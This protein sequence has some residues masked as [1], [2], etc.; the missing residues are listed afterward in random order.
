[1]N[2]LSLGLL[3]VALSLSAVSAYYSIVGLAAVFASSFWPVLILATILEVGKLVLVSWLYRNWSHTAW[4]IKIYLTSAVLILMVITSLGI[5]GFL[6]RAHDQD[7]VT[8][9]QIELQIAQIDSQI[10]IKQQQLAEARISW[11]QLNRTINIQLDANR[12]QQA[13][14]TR[15]VQQ[16]EKDRLQT[17]MQTIQEEMVTLT[18]QRTQ[19]QSNLNVQDSKLGP[20]TYVIGLFDPNADPKHSIRWI[21]LVLVLVC[22]PLAVLMLMAANQGYPASP[23]QTQTHSGIRWDAQH[24][25]IWVQDNDQNW[26]TWLPEQ[27]VDQTQNQ[28]KIVEQTVA[29]LMKQRPIWEV[30]SADYQTDS[31]YVPEKSNATSHGVDSEALQKLIISTLEK[32]MNNTLTV[33]YNLDETEITKIVE[34]IMQQTSQQSVPAAATPQEGPHIPQAETHVHQDLTT[35]GSARPIHNYFGEPRV[36]GG[37]K[38]QIQT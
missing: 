15:R 14:A 28:I 18:S 32:W 1:M 2:K 25:R 4:P 16:A 31:Q 13:L 33:T 37:K 6:S 11:D 24:K 20:V 12:A 21:I 7:Q 26:H 23:V 29:E 38:H 36:R 8:T 22:D 30:R 35:S 19:L 10:Q 3:A 9:K 27:A 34:K 17:R 5:F